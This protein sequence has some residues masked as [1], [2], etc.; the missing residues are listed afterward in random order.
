MAV[1]ILSGGSSEEKWGALEKQHLMPMP[2]PNRPRRKKSCLYSF[3]HVLVLYATNLLLLLTVWALPVRSH[4]RADDPSIAIYS[5]AN[6]AVE[7]IQEQRFRA[8][9]FNKTAY[10]GFPTDETAKLWSDLYNFGI[11]QISAE[12][13]RKLPYPTLAVPGT[14]NY[15]IELDVWHELHC[16]DDLRML[17]YPE[18]YP[19]LEELK[20]E[21]GTINRDT[22]AFR[23]WDHCVGSI[24]QTLMC[25]ADVSPISF[26]INV[27][28][29]TGIFPRLATTHTCR[30]F[31]KIQDWAKAHRARN[32]SFELSPEEVDRVIEAAGFDQSPLEDIEFLYDL[33]PGNTLFT[34]WREHS[35]EAEAARK[36]LEQEQ[37]T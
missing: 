6:E 21:N 36:R 4:S 16:L 37:S 14:D 11:S 25:H 30:N 5:P 7:Y 8:A 29:S 1:S 32:W 35:A 17:L 28:A 26:H 15:L 31:E 23:H 27:P 3:S 34:Y 33:F 18:R 13:A 10:M 9:L 12:E 20:F 19:G 22:D 2:Y 24:R